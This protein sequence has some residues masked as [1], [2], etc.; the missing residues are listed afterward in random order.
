MDFVQCVFLDLVTFYFKLSY[1]GWGW[2]LDLDHSHGF[3]YQQ[4]I[5]SV[6]N[7]NLNLLNSSPWC[8]LESNPLD[9]WLCQPSHA[10]TPQIWNPLPSAQ[11]LITWNAI[12]I[13]PTDQVECIDWDCISHNHLA[14]PYIPIGFAGGKNFEHCKTTTKMVLN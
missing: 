6:L 10:W 3:D 12:I 7:S 13:Y 4:Y 9:P 8:P 2:V 5:Y 14:F 1:W 11:F